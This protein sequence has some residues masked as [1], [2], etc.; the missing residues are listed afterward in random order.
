MNVLH[1]Y[2]NH[3]WT[4]PAELALQQVWALNA[5]GSCRADLALAGHHDPARPHAIAER[6]AELDLPVRE[7]L[8]LRRHFHLPSLFADSRHL[9]AWLD[10]GDVDVLHCHQPGDHLVAALAAHRA[11]RRVPVVRSYWENDVPGRGP[12]P[13]LSFHDTARVLAP[14]PSLADD[15]RRRFPRMASRVECMSPVLGPM[16]EPEP[17]DFHGSREALRTELSLGPEAFLV[18]LTARIQPNRRWD[19]AWDAIDRLS[20]RLPDVHLC[21][22]GRPDEGVFDRLCRNP[23]AER[24]ITHRV[25]FLGYRR[26]R[27]YAEALQALDA[28]LF[29]VPGSDATC[30]AL[31]EAMALGLPAVTTDLG[32]LP[33]ITIQESTGL[34]CQADGEEL[35]RALESLHDDA[36]LRERLG[37]EARAFARAHWAPDTTAAHLTSLYKELRGV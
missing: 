17:G 5:S 4:G 21:V 7:G 6:S 16:P 14:F 18:G 37:R 8:E 32:R 15:L 19:L 1:L 35:A 36:Q 9:A 27:A 22:L 13:W 23:L 26:G 24:G 34:R 2:A 25:H 12:R 28:F 20:R 29:L 30:R 33:E 11:K 31:R 10:T 3:K